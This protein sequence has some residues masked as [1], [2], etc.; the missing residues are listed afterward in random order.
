MTLR[1]VLA[2]VVGMVVSLVLIAYSKPAIRLYPLDS[3]A[4]ATRLPFPPPPVTLSYHSPAATVDKRHP[5]Y[6]A[7]PSSA[8]SLTP[9]SLPHSRHSPQLNM[10]QPEPITSP[11]P[12]A[13]PN[14]PVI[15][16]LT[17]S[18]A[19]P[20]KPKGTQ[21][22]VAVCFF[23]ITRSLRA[24]TFD[25]IRRCIFKKLEQQKFVYDVFIHTF[26]ATVMDN[27]RAGENNTEL[28]QEEWRLLNPLRYEIEDLADYDASKDF[29][30]FIRMGNPYFDRPGGNHTIKNHI[31]QMHS[32]RR[33]WHLVEQYMNQTNTRYHYVMFVRP[34]VRYGEP[35]LPDLD[36]YLKR[37]TT[38]YGQSGTPNLKLRV[39]I[40]YEDR[41]AVGT[42]EAIKLWATREDYA[43]EYVTSYKNN[44]TR[45][46]H[47]ESH[48]RWVMDKLNVNVVA[49]PMCFERVRAN[50]LVVTGDMASCHLPQWKKS[51]WRWAKEPTEAFRV[52]PYGN[53]PV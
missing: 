45:P 4:D 3:G 22:S 1:E 36:K 15:A 19:E 34:D 52:R 43:W 39:A 53:K 47:S 25:S 21:R 27:P 35:G 50:G 12:L 10:A 6:V 2:F 51:P 17:G 9:S 31:R 7:D 49:I 42:P 24:Y 48:L 13:R 40:A 44:Q 38:K 11:L 18:L 23:G 20:A 32:I 28:D 26:S 37:S 8:S 14:P 41:F 46:L 33:C 16:R 5:L 29:N 30:R